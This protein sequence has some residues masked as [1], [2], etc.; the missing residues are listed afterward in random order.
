MSELERQVQLTLAEIVAHD[1]VAPDLADRLTANALSGEQVVI[2]LHRRNRAIGPLLAAA[3]V[4]LLGA[5]ILV[6]TKITGAGSAVT[7]PVAPITSTQLPGPN[8]PSGGPEPTTTSG[9]STPE[10]ST[11]APTASSS[12]TRSALP[13]WITGRVSVASGLPVNFIPFSTQFVDSTTGFIIGTSRCGQGSGSCGGLYRT[14]DGGN[15]W[16]ILPALGVA[17]GGVAGGVACPIGNADAGSCVVTVRFTDALHGLAWGGPSVYTT[18]DGGD[19]WSVVSGG[20]Q[21]HSAAQIGSTILAV[22]VSDSSLRSHLLRSVDGAAFTKT[23]DPGISDS[24]NFLLASGNRW[25]VLSSSLDTGEWHFVSSTDAQ[26]WRTA[27]IPPCQVAS[28]FPG[29]GGSVIVACFGTAASGSILAAGAKSWTTFGGTPVAVTDGMSAE[30]VSARDTRHF[31]VLISDF[32]INVQQPYI[33]AVTAD[34]GRR[35]LTTKSAKAF[36]SPDDTVTPLTRTGDVLTGQL[37]IQRSIVTSKD[38]GQTWDAHVI[39]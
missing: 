21:V 36:P 27:P 22:D 33:W 23:S 3:V 20:H 8:A 24:I 2:P 30:M 31:A 12:G 19:T 32:R 18:S 10:F 34:G 1:P 28:A 4:V 26:Q 39:R 16:A 6:A 38:L 11:S 35:W 29:A 5:G 13:S 9:P 37:S 25:Y 15:S 17:A 7:P 14:G